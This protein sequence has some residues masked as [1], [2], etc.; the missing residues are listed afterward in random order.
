MMSGQA[1][2]MTQNV[3]SSLPGFPVNEVMGFQRVANLTGCVLQRANYNAQLRCMKEKTTQELVDIMTTN[4]IQ[5]IAPYADNQTVFTTE[6]YK[7]KGQAGRFAKVVSY[8]FCA[9]KNSTS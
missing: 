2:L 6:E 9:P 7:S 3:S 1:Q 4:N 8:L 5:G